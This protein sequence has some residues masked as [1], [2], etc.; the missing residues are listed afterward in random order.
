MELL[1]VLSGICPGIGLLDSIATL[2][3]LRNLHAVFHSGCTNLP[4][5]QQDV[6]STSSPA[7]VICRVFN[8]GCSDLCEVVP[9]YTS[10][11]HIFSCV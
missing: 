10:D 6:Y 4:S 2:S 11:L 9:H 7:S 5:H 8:D 1:I 3:F